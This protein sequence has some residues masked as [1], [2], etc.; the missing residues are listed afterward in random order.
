MHED[1]KNRILICI[2]ARLKG[3]GHGIKMGLEFYSWIGLGRRLVHTS[4]GLRGGIKI[5][6]EFFNKKT[7][8]IVRKVFIFQLFST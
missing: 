8:V 1:L 2:H 5:K 3:Q 7:M 4:M 6:L